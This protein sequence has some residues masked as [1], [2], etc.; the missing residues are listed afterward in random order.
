MAHAQIVYMPQVNFGKAT[1]ENN[2]DKMLA[3]RYSKI[4]KTH[5]K[6]RTILLVRSVRCSLV[7]DCTSDAVTASLRVYLLIYMPSHKP[8]IT[9]AVFPASPTRGIPNGDLK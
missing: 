7:V 4:E 5:F 9:L 6:R 2:K 1:G 3:L 8:V